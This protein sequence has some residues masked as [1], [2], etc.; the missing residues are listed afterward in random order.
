M[1]DILR[2][3]KRRWLLALLLIVSFTVTSCAGAKAG[4][5]IAIDGSS[6]VFPITQAVAEE[7][8]KKKQ[9]AEISVGVS[10][11]GGGMNKFCSGELDIAD[12]SRPIKD[13]ELK[14]CEEKKIEF[15]ELPVALDGAAVVVNK[16]N[17]F[18]DCLSIDDLKKMWSP[19]AT[20]KVKTW[21]QVND[22]FPDKPL[23]L[24]GPGTDSGT[25][26]YFTNAVNGKSKASRT[27]YT[28]SENDD[29]IAKGV[30]G[31]PNALGYFGVAYYEQNKDNLKLVGIRSPKGKCEKP[32][33]LENVTKNIYQPLS[34]P[35][36]IYVSAKAL[37]DKPEV[38]EFAQFYLENVTKLAKEVGYIG[39]PKENNEKV[40][41]KL[42]SSQ[43]GSKFKDAKPGDPIEKHLS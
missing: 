9:E 15:I 31:E 33:P 14:K 18:V 29:V 26:D 21:K 3:K 38:K 6:T 17:D 16:D 2:R 25:F 22:K 42:A 12:A 20:D 10:G 1:L 19:D 34:R 27:D 35:L 43:T 39:L 41:Q 24:Y 37:K 32:L 5:E 23:K 4:N 40:K 13:E 36:F 28:P 11:T 7:F 30:M 8:H